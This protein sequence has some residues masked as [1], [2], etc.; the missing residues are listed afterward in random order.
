MKTT[1]LS[2]LMALSLPAMAAQECVT[3]ETQTK[4]ILDGDSITFMSDM[5]F[6]GDASIVAGTYD[7]TEDLEDHPGISLDYYDYCDEGLWI[8]LYRGT[9]NLDCAGDS[10]SG[11]FYRGEAY[12][13]K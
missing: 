12:S 6:E 3:A 4:F 8:D 7:M 5:S 9:V 2:V 1:I 11:Y 10:G 13:C